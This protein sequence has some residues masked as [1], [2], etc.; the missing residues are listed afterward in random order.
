MIGHQLLQWIDCGSS[1]AWVVPI[2]EGIVTEW[3]RWF[4]GSRRLHLCLHHQLYA[5]AGEAGDA[6]FDRPAGRIHIDALGDQHRAI[7]G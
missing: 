4:A 7:L 5:V 2:T 6:E 3:P 1:L